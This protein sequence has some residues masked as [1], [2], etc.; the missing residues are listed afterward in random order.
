MGNSKKN[1]PLVLIVDDVPKNLQILGTILFQQGCEIAMAENGKVALAMLDEIDPDLIL[2]DVMMPEIDG[3]EVCEKIKSSPEKCE[4]PIIFLTA[5]TDPEDIVR[6]FRAGAVDYVTKPFNAEE[7]VSRVNT[8]LE[9]RD[10]TRKLKILNKTLEDKVEERTRELAKANERLAGLDS[11]K[12][13]FLSLLSH[14]LNTPIN[15]ISGFASILRSSAK[16]DELK[17]FTD[18]IIESSAR[19]KKYSDLSQLITRLKTKQYRFQKNPESLAKI[20]ETA[21]EGCIEK[22]REKN[23]AIN[24]KFK[25][26]RE[27]VSVDTYLVQK[28][29]ELIIENA[30][31]FSSPETEIII[32]ENPDDDF[33]TVSVID[34]GPG[35]EKDILDTLF[36][37]FV[38]DEIMHHKEGFGLGLATA[39]MIMETHSGRITAENRREKGAKVH[40]RFKC[41]NN[42]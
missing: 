28:V 42:N 22:A 12:N 24:N 18:L 4:I 13:Y 16:D 19:L 7:L 17:E 27:L 14:E 9:L 34:S 35:F 36:E 40:L 25:S 1:K 31:K 26:G 32:D 23:I 15:E 30:I 41:E 21:V 38:A 39:K 10:K 8:Q 29:F 20:I 3:Y 37:M 33:L 11:A 6:G 2:L 5:K